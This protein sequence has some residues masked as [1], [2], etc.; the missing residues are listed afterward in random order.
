[1]S[2]LVSMG[3]IKTSPEIRKR[4]RVHVAS[5]DKKMGE[6]IEEAII[7]AL[8]SETMSAQ[9]GKGERNENQKDEHETHHV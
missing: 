1:M 3:N 4:V 7:A 6:W 8:E 5:I 2:D 9:N